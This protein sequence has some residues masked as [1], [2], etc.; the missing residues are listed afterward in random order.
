MTTASRVTTP[1]IG[2]DEAQDDAG[3]AI[4]RERDVEVRPV[5]GELGRARMVALEQDRLAPDTMSVPVTVQRPVDR[6][7]WQYPAGWTKV[8]GSVSAGSGVIGS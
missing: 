1:P 6:T 7:F 2:L 3:V 4:D 8:S 5:A